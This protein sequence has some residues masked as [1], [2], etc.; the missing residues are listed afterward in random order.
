M[1][2]HDHLSNRP[3][4]EFKHYIDSLDQIKVDRTLLN[5]NKRTLQTGFMAQQAQKQQNQQSIHHRKN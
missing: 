1:K 4:S 2:V 5:S 3:P